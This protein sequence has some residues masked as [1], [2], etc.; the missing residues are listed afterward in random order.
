MKKYFLILF[1]FCVS[2]AFAS[3]VID[4][5]RLNSLGFKP[6]MTK[7]A[8]IASQ[9]GEITVK[10]AS[11][12]KTVYVGKAVGPFDS[13]DTGE[14]V[15]TFDFSAVKVPGTYYIEA[16]PIGRSFDFKVADNV[17]DAAFLT[18]T[19]GMY[20]W[21]CGTAVSGNYGKD[22]FYTEEC[23][24]DDAYLELAGGKGKIDGTGGWHDA[25]D[26]GKYTVNAGITVGLMLKA[27]EHFEG[28]IKRINLNIPESGKGMPDFLAEIKWE[29]DW[30][31][32]MQAED[33]SVYHK[34]STASFPGSIMPQADIIRRYYA[35]WSS[36]ATADFCAMLAGAARNLKAYDPGTAEKYIRAAKKSMDFLLLNPENHKADQ[37]GFSTGLYETGDADDR[38][39]ALAELWEATGEEKYLK[40]FEK[41]AGQYPVKIDTDWDWG[42]VKNLAMLTYLFSN[43]SGRDGAIVDDI[44]V[45]LL[46]CADERVETSLNNPYGRTL[47]KSYYWGSNGSVARQALVL[48]CANRIQPSEKYT[49]AAAETVGHLFGR[50]YYCRSYVTGLGY[51]P[52]LNPHD[53]RAMADKIKEPWPGYLAGGGLNATGWQDDAASFTTNEIAINWNGALIYALAGMLYDGPDYTP[54]ATVTGTPPTLTPTPVPQPKDLIYD[55]ETAG[56]SV[57]SGS[58]EV[59]GKGIYDVKTGPK[60]KAM[61]LNFKGGREEQKA[62]L[63]KKPRQIGGFN[64]IEFDIKSVRYAVDDVYFGISLSASYDKLLNIKD[65]LPK[66]VITEKWARVRMPVAEMISYGAS[67]ISEL[68]WVTNQK[69]KAAILVDNIRLVKYTPPS[70]TITPT[71]TVSPIYTATPTSTASPTST[72]TMFVTA[73]ATPSITPTITVSPTATATMTIT[74]ETGF[75]LIVDNSTNDSNV[76]LQGGS[77]YTYDDKTNGGNSKIWPEPGKTFEKSGRTKDGKGR[78]AVMK[79]NVT[80]IFQWGYMGMGTT[81]DKGGKSINLTK[82]T[83]LRFWHK[84]DGK[85]YRVKA[86]STHPD[87]KDGTGDNQFGFEFVSEKDWQLFE[88]DLS[89]FTQEP[90]W[91]SVVDQ[92]KALSMI[93][94]LQW[95]TRGQPLENVELMIDGVE[96]YGCEDKSIKN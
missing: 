45:K 41:N 81:L 71:W 14:Q 55:G 20:L 96:I 75:K 38:L 2:P 52:V 60:K 66:G 63:M 61:A 35:P 33:G 91:G 49:R 22:T 90:Y 65:Y 85:T 30:V 27:W 89:D 56:Y 86:V 39:W 47:G 15:Y 92:E 78:A 13:A 48:H 84:G 53:R 21:R 43:R 19:R 77:W 94:D 72:D 73:T 42:N 3:D 7:I 8:S 17:Y 50:N 28:N 69:T 67:S 24:M 31:L 59:M 34:I 64:Y 10:S 87:F 83:G 11:D 36:A 32:K 6:E 46:K 4:K 54:T 88:T 70:P 57:L 23:H 51:K 76:N 62:W 25:G 74:P 29:T 68:V 95:Q 80:V 82:C 37:K 9:C 12:N 79:G 40:E 26:Y 44:K 16:L 5:I 58:A 1:L 18:V 93:K